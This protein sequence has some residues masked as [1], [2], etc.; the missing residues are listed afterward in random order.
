MPSAFSSRPTPD[1]R[2]ARER[3]VICLSPTVRFG[4]PLACRAMNSCMDPAPGGHVPVGTWT[5]HRLLKCGSDWDLRRGSERGARGPG[6]HDCSAR[7]RPRD[8]T[9]KAALGLGVW[10][11]S[12]RNGGRGSPVGWE[13]FSAPTRRRS[14]P[15]AGVV[16]GHVPGSALVGGHVRTLSPAPCFL[17]RPSCFVHRSLPKNA[18]FLP[19]LSIPPAATCASHLH[20][21]RQ[22]RQRRS[23][24]A[25][26]SPKFDYF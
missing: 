5:A 7:R 2:P 20:I 14:S 12:S 26:L 25:P 23:F 15:A 24:N 13:Q 11:R 8:S 9:E 4:T 22:V 21:F 6:E 1:R 17:P 18:A 19:R 10:S 3:G 16:P